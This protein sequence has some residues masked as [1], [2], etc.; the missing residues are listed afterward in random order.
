VL[1]IFL[2]ACKLENKEKA[3]SDLISVG[4]IS[5]QDGRAFSNYEMGIIKALCNNLENKRKFL[6]A[7]EDLSIKFGFNLS[8]T[9]CSLVDYE[10]RDLQIKV[11]KVN[12]TE[13][14]YLANFKSGFIEDVIT[15]KSD[16][17]KYLCDNKDAKKLNNYYYDS[18]NEMY[19]FNVLINQGFHRVEYIKSVLDNGGVRVPKVAEG[20]DFLSETYQ[21]SKI[22]FF[23]VEKER[24]RYKQCTTGANVSTHSQTWLKEI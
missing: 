13:F 10:A 18:K 19:S 12:D 6:S 14:K 8:T 21:T 20:I 7:N 5:I 16:V 3:K 4:E 11:S 1:V 17:F 24:T 23:G 2:G 15:D 22:E 9:N